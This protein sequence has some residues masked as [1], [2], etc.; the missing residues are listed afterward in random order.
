MEITVFHRLMPEK[1]ERIKNTGL[2]SMEI[3]L[4]R[5]KSTQA[6]REL[7]EAELFL[8]PENRRWIFH[9]RQPDVS[10]RLERNYRSKLSCP[11]SRLKPGLKRKRNMMPLDAAQ[12]ALRSESA[13]LSRRNDFRQVA[14]EEFEWRASF[15]PS[16]RWQPARLAFSDRHALPIQQ[17]KR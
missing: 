3:D 4:S 13:R 2:A 5:F 8:N 9:P 6:T 14:D 7:L 12:R 15:P 16:E 1:R 11:K 10:E 17:S